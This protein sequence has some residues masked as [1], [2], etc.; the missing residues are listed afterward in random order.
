M[1]EEDKKITGYA[2]EC[3]LKQGAEAARINLAKGLSNSIEVCD[4]KLEKIIGAADKSLGIEIF[5]HGH[6]GRFSTNMLDEHK[7]DGFIKECI[8]TLEFVEKDRFRRLP[9]EKYYFKGQSRDFGINDSSFELTSP[10]S[11]KQSAFAIFDEMNN[12]EGLVSASSSYSDLYYSEYIL[13]SQG[14]SGLSEYTSSTVSAECT[15][16]DGDRRPQSYWYASSP[17]FKD[18]EWKG[19]GEKAYRRTKAKMG[20]RTIASGKYRVKIDTLVAQNMIKP[21]A[22]ALSGVFLAQNNSFLL[23]RLG[24]KV[25]SS[26]LSILDRAVMQGRTSSRL[27]D[28]EGLEVRDCL[29]IDK[30]VVAKEY[31]STY[32]AAQMGKEPTVDE[33]TILSIKPFGNANLA[34]GIL[35]TG[36][37]GGNCNTATGD[38]SYGIEGFLIE[39][40]EVITAVSG[41]NFSGNLVTLFNNICAAGNDALEFRSWDIPS[42]VFEDCNINGN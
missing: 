23:D 1:K 2:L 29:M 17:F 31:L 42:L 40:N 12:K 13:D 4:G 30:G 24:S 27:W 39:N 15:L 8:S 37:N 16:K 7:L 28:S 22:E 18:L 34:D 25:F 38:F 20:S 19:C 36:F 26:K 3:V 9:K 32:E 11:K 14:F 35:I 21:L 41:M 6:Y 5:C 33:P 10:D